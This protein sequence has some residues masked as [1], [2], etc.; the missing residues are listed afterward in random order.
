MAALPIQELEASE[1]DVFRTQSRKRGA[2]RKNEY[3]KFRKKKIP[4][5]RTCK[6]CGKDPAPNYFFCPSCHYRVSKITEGDELNI[7]LDES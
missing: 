5:G 3:K 1:P 4:S 6:V 2:K 7:Q